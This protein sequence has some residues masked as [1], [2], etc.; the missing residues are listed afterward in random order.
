M[1]QGGFGYSSLGV[2]KFLDG[3][4][5]VM[6]ASGA[7]IF[8]LGQKTCPGG[9]V[10]DLETTENDRVVGL[11]EKPVAAFVCAGVICSE[12]L[13]LEIPKKGRFKRRNW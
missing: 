13:M 2:R 10:G 8:S 6:W 4:T 7:T 5:H 11:K 9:D 1:P 3:F 12:G